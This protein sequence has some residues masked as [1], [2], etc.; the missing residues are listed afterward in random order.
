M[1]DTLTFGHPRGG[2]ANPKTPDEVTMRNESVRTNGAANPPYSLRGFES[3]L[4]SE[5]GRL[6]A[7][8]PEGA[9]RLHIGRVPGHPDWVEPYFEVAPANPRAA[10]FKGVVVID[11]LN[12]TIGTASFREFF[13][14]ARGGTIFKGASWQEEFRWIWLAVVK[15]GFT[16][17]LYRSSNGRVIG[18]ATKLSVNG[19]DLAIRNGTRFEG[20]FRSAKVERIKFEPYVMAR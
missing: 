20:L 4:I 3:E 15:G 12:L 9:A 8:L 1:A 13:C 7:D 6:V 2:L 19:K 14:F 17:N 10:P 5:L 18:W 11:D 16:E